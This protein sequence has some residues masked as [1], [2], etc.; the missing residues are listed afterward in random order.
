[1][2]PSPSH[3]STSR[4]GDYNNHSLVPEENGWGLAW[5]LDCSIVFLPSRTLIHHDGT[6][7]QARR[8]LRGCE[9]TGIRPKQ[10]DQFARRSVFRAADEVGDDGK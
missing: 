3:E 6:T 5:R 1:M 2:S 9:L 10:I 7:M 4:K 8:A